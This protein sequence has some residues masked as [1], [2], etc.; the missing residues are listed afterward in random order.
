MAQWMWQAKAYCTVDRWMTH[1]LHLVSVLHQGVWLGLLDRHGFHHIAE[2]QYLN[3]T[4][5]RDPDYNRSGLWWWEEAMLER[6]FGSC[7]SILVG[8][9]G[10]G[11]E[12][13][14]LTRRGIQVDAFECAP[15]L[16]EYCRELLAAERIVTRVAVAFPDQVPEELGLYEGLLMGWG[17]YMHIAG[18]E[19]RIQFLQQCRRHLRPGGP[20]LL[21][22]FV[23]GTEAKRFRW[24]YH[25]AQTIRRLHKPG[26]LVELGDTLSGTFDHYFTKEEIQR[27]LVAAG[28]TLEY[29]ADTPYGHAVGRAILG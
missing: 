3:W 9:A 20:I 14:A 11:R 10:G 1:A 18:Q 16:I 28:F 24:I 22:F 21:S 29:Y 27:E 26:E 13:L 6:F 2:Q 19:T 4:R 25:I 12:V 23:R 17:G 5:Y 7:Q 15:G 8:A